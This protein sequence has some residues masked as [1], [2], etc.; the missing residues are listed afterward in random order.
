MTSTGYFASWYR[1][2][3]AHLL[4]PLAKPLWDKLSPRAQKIAAEIAPR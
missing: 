3:P 1:G 2:V 4:T